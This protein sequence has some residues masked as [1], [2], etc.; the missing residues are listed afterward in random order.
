MTRLEQLQAEISQL[1]P[2]ERR[3]LRY[4]LEELVSDDWDQQMEADALAGKLDWLI[5]EVRADIRAGRTLPL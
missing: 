3:S 5:E 2:P 4:W 1:T